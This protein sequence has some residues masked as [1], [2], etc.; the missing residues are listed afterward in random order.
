[1]L[2][3]HSE[4]LE[5]DGHKIH[6]VWWI[7][8]TF[9]QKL[10]Q[11][12][13]C[14]MLWMGVH[15]IL[16]K[17]H[18]L[19]ELVEAP[20][21]ATVLCSSSLHSLLTH[22]PRNRESQNVINNTFPCP[23]SSVKLPL[24]ITCVFI[25]SPIQWRQIRQ[26]EIISHLEK[27]FKIVQSVAHVETHIFTEYEYENISTLCAA[28]CIIHFC[29]NRT[30]DAGNVKSYQ[31]NTH[32]NDLWTHEFWCMSQMSVYF[33]RKHSIMLDFLLIFLPMKIQG[34]SLF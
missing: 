28:S 17:D 25:T 33:A 4:E 21:G 19:Q 31:T 5:I 3:Q 10:L 30:K 34:A 2:L 11:D 14:D 8:K 27:V 22:G 29:L 20:S 26:S 6:T 1:M 23:D 15:V 16:V 9:P 24:M 18:F 32:I 13:H 12:F 7:G